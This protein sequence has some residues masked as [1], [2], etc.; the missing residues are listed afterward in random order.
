M[1]K[2]ITLHF[3]KTGLQTSVQ[4]QGRIGHQAFGVPVS[5]AMDKSSTRI[6][7]WLVGN[8]LNAPVLEITLLGPKIEIEG[9]CQIAITGGD[10]S[11]TIDKNPIPMYETIHVKNGSVL[12][13]GRIQNGCR[14]Y[15]AVGGKWHIKKWLGSYS[16]ST[17]SGAGQICKSEVMTSVS[18][19]FCAII[20][21]NSFIIITPCTPISKRVYPKQYRP[22]YELDF[23]LRVLPGPEFEEFSN[24]SVA[25]F[26]GNSHCISVDS[27]RMGYRLKEPIIDFKSQREVISSGIIPGS[28]QVT[29]SGQLIILMADAQTTGGYHR[30]LNVISADMDRLGQMKPGDEVRF[31]MI[32]REEALDSLQRQYEN[33]KKV[34]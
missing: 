9:D 13:F 7:N 33:E 2:S 10:L 3:R 11:T 1:S 16:V 15:L 29:S 31:S 8:P 24:Y 20:Q 18:T 4:D 32:Q 5:G 14:A 21:K 19:S 12:S 34:F 22:G 23:R 25:Y 6:A 17:H 28:I 30:F 27:N 26:F